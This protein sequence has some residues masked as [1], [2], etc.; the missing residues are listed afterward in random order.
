MSSHV[1]LDRLAASQVEAVI[2]AAVATAQDRRVAVSIAVVDAGG[3]LVGFLRMN[4]VHSATADVA[5]SKARSAAAFRR[6]TRLFAEQLAAGNLSMLAISGCVPLQGGIP[7]V[8]DGRLAG[9]VGI[10][11]AAPD[12]DDVIARSAEAAVLSIGQSRH[13][14]TAES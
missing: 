1:E 2:A 7:F 8:A 3:H 4:G 12:V 13:V 9:A 6:P 10:S 14:K 5:L 11:G